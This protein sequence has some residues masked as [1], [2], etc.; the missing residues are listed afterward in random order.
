[1]KSAARV[2]FLMG[3]L[4][5]A[6]CGRSVVPGTTYD[7]PLLSFQGTVNPAGGLLQAKHPIVGLLWTDPLQRQPDVPMPARWFGSSVSETDDTFSVEVF[8]PPPPQAVVTVASA[9]SGTSQ[10]AVAEIVIVDDQDGDGTFRVSGPRATIASPEIYLAGSA[11][12]LTYVVS[13]F[14]SPQ[15][16]SPLTLPGQSGYALVNYNCLGQISGSTNPVNPQKVEL[17]LQPSYD[18]PD[19]RPC[20]ASHGP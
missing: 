16:N 18:F 1:L 20:R 14:S 8:R 17:I 11:N 13:P 2:V 10:L 7:Q 3:V 6:A 15:I 9:S 5:G 4:G 12:V 19:V